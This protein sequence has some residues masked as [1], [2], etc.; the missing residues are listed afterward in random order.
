MGIIRSIASIYRYAPRSMN[1]LGLPHIFVEQ[2]CHH[3]KSLLSHINTGT[4]LGISMTAQLE[5]CAIEIGSTNPMF[6]LPF[7]HWE[8]LLTECWM[9]NIWQFIDKYGIEIRGNYERPQSNREKDIGLMD[10]IMDYYSPP[11]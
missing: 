8:Y 2:G 9:K 10:I 7:V 5:A 1:G 4:K 11:L 3:I 6:T